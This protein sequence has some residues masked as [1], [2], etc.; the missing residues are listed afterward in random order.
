MFHHPMRAFLPTVMLLLQVVSFTA[1]QEDCPT[2]VSQALNTVGNICANIRRNQVC[3]GN[4]SV[5][6]TARDS[7]PLSNFSLPGDLTSV[8]NM[9]TLETAPLNIKDHTWGVAVMAVQANL[10]DTL[11]GQN[12]TFI[13]FGNVTLEADHNPDS[14]FSA[15]MQAFRLTARVGD[16]A[17]SEAPRDGMLVQTPQG[18]KVE[19]LVNGVQL[20]IASTAFI[21]TTGNDGLNVSTLQGQVEVSSAG[22][23]K[24]VSAGNQLMTNAQGLLPSRAAPYNLANVAALPLGL[25]PEAVNVPIPVPGQSDWLDSGIAVTAGQTFTLTASG[26]VNPCAN[27][28][29]AVCK[30]YG[31]DGMTQL[32]TVTQA[33]PGQASNYPMPDAIIAALVGRIGQG[34]PFYVGAGGTFT[35]DSDGTLQFRIND[36][37]L[38]NN[39]GTFFVEVNTDNQIPDGQLI[40]LLNCATKGGVT[41]Q[42]SQALVFRGGWSEFKMDDL[43]AFVHERTVGLQYDGKPLQVTAVIGPA[44]WTDPQ[45][46]AGYQMNWYWRLTA[47]SSGAHELTWTLGQ[48]SLTC[49]VTVE[50]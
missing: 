35:A 48:E 9:A 6:A 12:V 46:R 4:S 13:I 25:L 45:G 7:S 26:T 47:P 38:E 42:S 50:A 34:E 24:A 2:M 27:Q 30:P 40:G 23:T 8:V 18:T 21:T 20:E 49:K 11:P 28:T 22:G 33:E 43:R 10:P 5:T 3:Y 16:T 17:C 39:E 37:P 29:T 32:G 31:P 41:V 44:A 36:N 19:F 14:R 15:P 1:A